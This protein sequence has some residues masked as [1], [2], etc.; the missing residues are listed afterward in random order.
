MNYIGQNDQ[1]A[2]RRVLFAYD[3]QICPG[4]A[5]IA[6]EDSA[7]RREYQLIADSLRINNLYRGAAME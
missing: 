7:D 3:W 5:L 1:W 2:Q 4:F 6:F